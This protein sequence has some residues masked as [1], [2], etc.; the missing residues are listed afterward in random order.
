MT[1]LRA[2]ARADASASAPVRLEVVNGGLLKL[3]HGAWCEH[4]RA[5]N[6]AAVIDI[7]GTA[8]GGFSRRFLPYG[9]GPVFYLVEQ[10]AL[11][12]AIE[13]AGDAVSFSGRVRASRVFAVVVVKTD[14]FI[15]VETFEDGAAAVLASKAKRTTKE[16]VLK[17]LGA[18]RRHYES[19]AAE[20]AREMAEVEKGDKS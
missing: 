9:R 19:R 13:F 1:E 8:P 16:D 4:H 11:F 10:V 20:L 3:P 7:D 2:P 14:D 17:A 5:K 15:E 18:E 12:D 6:W